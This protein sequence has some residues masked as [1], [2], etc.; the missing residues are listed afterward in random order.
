ME[1]RQGYVRHDRFNIDERDWLEDSSIV[2]RW[3]KTDW[4]Y[5][6]VDAGGL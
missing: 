4:D 3:A 6:P 2:I 1:E 5:S